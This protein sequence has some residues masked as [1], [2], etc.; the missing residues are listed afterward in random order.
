MLA[1]TPLQRCVAPILVGVHRRCV[2]VLLEAVAAAVSGPRQ[3]LIEIGRHFRG[4]LGL[5]HP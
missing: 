5:R 1:L 4:G 2:A 3:T